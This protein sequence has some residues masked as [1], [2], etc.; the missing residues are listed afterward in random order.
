MIYALPKVSYE[1]KVFEICNDLFG[2]G[3]CTLFEG[4]DSIGITFLELFFD[5]F[6]VSLHSRLG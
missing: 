6:H 3:L 5:C 2:E 4:R 1:F